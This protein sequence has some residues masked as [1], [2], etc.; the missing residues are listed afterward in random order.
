MLS[1]AASRPATILAWISPRRVLR[2][3]RASMTQDPTW[4]SSASVCSDVSPTLGLLL[5]PAPSPSS[6]TLCFPFS[7][8]SSNLLH[9]F[10]SCQHSWQLHVHPSGSHRQSDYHVMHRMQFFSGIMIPSPWSPP[11]E[12][13]LVFEEVPDLGQPLAVTLPAPLASAPPPSLTPATLLC[14]AA[15][16][17]SPPPVSPF[18]ASVSPPLPPP[19][20]STASPPP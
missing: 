5:G 2:A 14:A 3:Q 20:P 9:G 4:G 12:S 13:V 15:P 19:A 18:P 16:S 1:N 6:S 8:G 11:P 17:I 10:F 7:L